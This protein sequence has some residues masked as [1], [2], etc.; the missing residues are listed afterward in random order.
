MKYKDINE[1]GVI[2]SKDQIDL[3]KGGWSTAPFTF[4]INLKL[5]YKNFSLFALGNGQTGA[6]GMKNNSY[7]WNRGTSKF[8][9]VVWNRWTYKTAE[10]ATYPRLTTGNGDNN[11]RNST[12]W[13]YKTNMFKLANVQF[14]YDFRKV[15]STERLFADSV[16]IVVVATC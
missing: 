6:I 9:E 3:G 13:M 10:T 8:S 2:D 16:C 5:K 7:Y 11:Y 14:N 1:D 4:G 15:H 12:F